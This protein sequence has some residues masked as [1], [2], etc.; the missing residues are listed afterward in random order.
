[1]SAQETEQLNISRVAADV[2][3]R[4]VAEAAE[5]G[6]SINDLLTAILA[7]K[8]RVRF[9]RT[10]RRGS[11]ARTVEGPMNLRVPSS[12]KRRVDEAVARQP[13]GQR[14]IVALVDSLLRE[15][16]DLVAVAAA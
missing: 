10:G 3:E 16:Y 13:K 5:Q 12:L 6:S 7:E 15:R 8:Y 11:G 9:D 2:K 4:L 14:S 1:M